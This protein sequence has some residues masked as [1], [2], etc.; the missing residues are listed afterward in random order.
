MPS[1]N[2]LGEFN[3]FYIQFDF[4]FPWKVRVANASP[5]HDLIRCNA[6]SYFASYCCSVNDDNALASLTIRLFRRILWRFVVLLNFF[7]WN[8]LIS[9]SRVKK[10]VE[11]MV[12]YGWSALK[13]FD[14]V[15][16]L[17][18]N[19]T[20]RRD[21]KMVMCYTLAKNGSCVS[22]KDLKPIT[23]VSLSTTQLRIWILLLS[24]GS[25]W[26]S[27]IYMRHLSTRRIVLRKCRSDLRS[28]FKLHCLKIALAM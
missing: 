2:G 21:N 23:S 10:T 4:L 26:L 24:V 6:I 1:P 11:N 25:L 18:S 28:M 17:I 12:E 14:S 5:V 8:S 20:E 19:V 7:Y 9:W 13:P 27:E 22:C 3:A 16:N 15:F